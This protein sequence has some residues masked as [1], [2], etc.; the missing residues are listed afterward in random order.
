MTDL[1]AAARQRLV[2]TLSGMPDLATEHRRRELLVLAGLERGPALDVSGEP[3]EAVARIVHDLIRASGPHALGLFLN[4][5][6]TFA[7]EEQHAVLDGVLTG[8]DLMV[9]VVRSPGAGTWH[10]AATEGSDRANPLRPMAFLSAAVAAARCVAHV[11]V[12]TAARSWSG[13]GFLVGPDVLL[14][15]NHVLPRADLALTTTFRFN[16][17]DDADG[18]PERHDDYAGA[19]GGLFHTSKDLDYTLVQLAGRPGD[20]WAYLPL[21]AETLAAG[22]RM[23]VVAHP[24]GQ[25]KQVAL[26]DAQVA[27][28][29]GGV[30]QYVTQALPGSSGAPLFTDEWRVCAVHRAA[31]PA[32]SRT[33]FRNEGTMVSAI[34]RDL[35]ASVRS[36]LPVGGVAP[37]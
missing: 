27:Y 11:G 12:T 26:R 10:G 6:K 16:Y 2:R 32:A 22:D 30:V 19:P 3:A 31:G 28:V 35:P 14:T 9:P 8:Y 25:P 13:T 5:V 4:L 17:Q 20:R 24:A 21:A 23:S 36:V 18:R 7:D 1:D 15:A 29:G 33:F 34:L 37:V